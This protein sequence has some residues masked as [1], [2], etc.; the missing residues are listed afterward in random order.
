MDMRN[1]LQVRHMGSAK[2]KVALN[3]LC[4]LGQVLSLSGPQFPQLQNMGVVTGDCS[5]G[6]SGILTRS[7]FSCGCLVQE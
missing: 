6:T 3:S 7:L 5:P 2:E 1:S 4:D